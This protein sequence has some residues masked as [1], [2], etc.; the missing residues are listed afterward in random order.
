MSIRNIMCL[1]VRM[2]ACGIEKSSQ[3]VLCFH[4]SV[5]VC[6]ASCPRTACAL[7]FFRKIFLSYSKP[8]LLCLKHHCDER[9][10]FV[11]TLEHILR[12]RQ[13]MFENLIIFTEEKSLPTHEVI[14]F[15]PLLFILQNVFYFVFF[16]FAYKDHF[17]RGNGICIC[18]VWL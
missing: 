8:W 18:V 12:I 11:I 5:D 6:S 3:S 4:R 9:L 2:T 17:C 1:R 13:I 16:V 7:F 10:T 15:S 14:R